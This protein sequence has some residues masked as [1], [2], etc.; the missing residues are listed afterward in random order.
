MNVFTVSLFGHRELEDIHQIRAQLY[1]IIKKLLQSKNYISF[2][3]GRNG[4]FDE[5]AASLIKQAQKEFGKEN[6]DMSLVLPYAIANLEYYE[7]YYDSIILPEV[8]YNAHP[9][10]AITLKNRWMIEK[11]DLIIVYSSH[12]K[13]GSYAALRYAQ[14]LNKK[15]FFLCKKATAPNNPRLLD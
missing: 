3:I 13:G 10:A 1:P 11:S 6:N 14:K 7:K 8:V 4:A 5:Y 9:K 12:N 15:I 2:L